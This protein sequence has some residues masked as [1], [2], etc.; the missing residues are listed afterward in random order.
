MKMQS[1]FFVGINLAL[2]VTRLTPWQRN[3]FLSV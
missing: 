2:L 1:A 3:G